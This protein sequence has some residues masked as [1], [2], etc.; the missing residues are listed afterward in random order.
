MMWRATSAVTAL[1]VGMAACGGTI[2]IKPP[3]RAP[4][5]Q[6]L[7]QL[8]VDPGSESRDLFWGIGGQKYAPDRDAVFKFQARDA[9]GFSTKYDVEGPDGVEWSAKI[10]EE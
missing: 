6:D 3:D 8:W 7:K 1:A 2:A 4:S 9:T 5:A 10:G